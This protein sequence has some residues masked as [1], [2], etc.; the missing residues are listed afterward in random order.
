MRPIDADRLKTIQSIQN[1]DFN[2]IETIQ[3]WIDNA[4]TIDPVRHGKW[5]GGDGKPKKDSFSVYCSACGK[6]SEYRTKYCGE[7]GAKMDTE[8]SE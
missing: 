7:C 5:V 2:S 3:R 8:R 1:A 4:P 6:W